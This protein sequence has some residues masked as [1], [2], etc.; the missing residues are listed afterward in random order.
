ME[1]KITIDATPALLAALRALV[2]QPEAVKPDPVKTAMA[3]AVLEKQLIA[4]GALEPKKKKKEPTAQQLADAETIAKVFEGKDTATETELIDALI[5]ADAT[6]GS[7]HTIESL[8]AIAVPKSKAGHKD[9]IKKWLADRDYPSLQ[10][11]QP[12]D[13]TPFY[14]FINTL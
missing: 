2:S 7:V 6:N 5:K 8:R 4:V 1:I 11:L 9:A 10:D 3:D 14:N 13:F 12:A